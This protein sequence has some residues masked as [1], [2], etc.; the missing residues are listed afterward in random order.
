MNTLRTLQ[1]NRAIFA[2]YLVAI[3]LLLLVSALRPGFASPDHLRV[4]AIEAA[5]VGIISMGQTFTVITG[6]IDLSIPWVLNAAAVVITLWTQGTNTNWFL[7]VVVI[8]VACGIVGAINGIGVSYLRINPVIMTLGMSSILE[9]GF[10]GLLN[11]SAGGNA[12]PI[13][14]SMATGELSFIPTLLAIWASLTLLVTIVL[15]YTPYGRRL[16]AI[17]NNATAARFSGV[18]VN[19]T[20]V[21]AYV[22]S[23]LCAG[24]GGILLSGYIGQS[25]LG[26]GDP[27]L[28]QSVAAVA[29]GGA[30][31]LG[32]N[33]HYLGTVA[34]AFML[35]I[36]AALLPIFQLPD[37]A[38]Q[39]LYGVVVLVAVALSRG[40]VADRS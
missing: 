12:P 19:T 9:G 2:S 7:D 13:I 28:F 11:G 36:L 34:G 32:G 8:E 5:L 15:S 35:T 22:L 31:L 29:I 33:G 40:R 24:L 25:Y 26:M 18:N 3:L 1:R 14:Q 4:I 21:F 38:Q 10:I 6:G 37:A 16:Y 30:S 39:I 23:S 27:Y 17:G 20:R